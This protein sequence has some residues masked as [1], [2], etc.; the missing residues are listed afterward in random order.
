MERFP[1]GHRIKLILRRAVD[2]FAEAVGFRRTDVGTP[3]PDL[4]NG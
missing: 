3:M 1:E 2:A 4:L